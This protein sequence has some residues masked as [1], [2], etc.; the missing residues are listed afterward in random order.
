MSRVVDILRDLV[1]I[2]S[3]NL[4]LP[5][6]AH[7]ERAVTEYVDE[8]CRRL[9]LEPVEGGQ[10][11]DGRR[12]AV[13]LLRVPGATQT[14]MFEA[15]MDTV[16]LANMP[17]GTN[18][19]VEG[20]RLY[21][22]G[23][24]DTKGS[25]AAMLGA[26]AELAKNPQGL[27]ANILVGGI[28]EEETGLV[29]ARLA[30]EAGLRP[31]GIVV[32]E[33]TMLQPVVAHKGVTRFW[34]QTR[35]QSA[36]TSQPEYGNSAIIQMMAVIRHLQERVAPTFAHRSHE[37]VGNPVQTVAMIEG[38]HQIN[39]VPEACRI[40]V[41]RRT[42]P[43]EDPAEVLEEYRQALAELCAE[44]PGVQAEIE[45]VVSLTPG[46]HSPPDS[47]VVRAALGAARVVLGREVEPAGAPFGTDAS[48]YWGMEKIPCVVLGP[49]DIAQAHT[50][51]EWIALEQLETAVPLFVELARR[52]GSGGN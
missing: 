8:F 24:C 11:P 5:G 51:N 44:Q 20:G 46:L 12:N 3:V 2:E 27:H 33:P 23:A 35:G 47:D 29:G 16:T 6:A 4:N 32:G 15:H 13:W 19:R 28:L 49:G 39:F 34:I 45:S 17:D 14:L 30:M 26:V 48:R 22:R 50:D 52:F 37:L 9:D 36:H 41:D 18:P 42:L 38:G 31:D 21:G 40:A 1:S 7:G 10:L 43:F 25:L